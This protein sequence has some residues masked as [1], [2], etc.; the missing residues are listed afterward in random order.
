MFADKISKRQLFMILISL[1]LVLGIAALV[2]L[3][4]HR[5]IIKSKASV[6][7]YDNFEL[8][9]PDGSVLRF[10]DTPGVNIQSSGQRLYQT[11]DL[12]VTIRIK[13]LNGLV[14]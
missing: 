14:P 10:R 11:N 8:T 3:S 4:T 13:D 6:N 7:P 9:A 2:Y 5:Q 1:L 12:D